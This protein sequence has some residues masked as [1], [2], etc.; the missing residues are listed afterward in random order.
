MD[1]KD[2]RD[3]LPEDEYLKQMS[4]LPKVKAPDDFL[5]KVR[6]RIERR[7]FRERMVDALFV[8][9]RIKIPL[10]VAAVTATLLLVISSL[11]V[12]RPSKHLASVPRSDVETAVIGKTEDSKARVFISRNEEKAKENVEAE[13]GMIIMDN[14]EYG[15]KAADHALED[16]KPVLQE[17]S[18]TVASLKI[19]SEPA[20]APASAPVEAGVSFECLK[21]KKMEYKETELSEAVAPSRG[22]RQADTF[23]AVTGL[24]AS[25]QGT[26]TGIGTDKDMGPAQ[27]IDAEIP[28]ANYELFKKKLED[29]AISGKV[30]MQPILKEAPQDRNIIQVRIIITGTF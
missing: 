13:K 12:I 9:F 25:V 16:S 19:A 14:I 22:L 21:A 10:E 6:E 2:K 17:K 11:D 23:S 4:S 7:T 8:P 15:G 26:V 3:M 27:Y 18:D 28:V 20:A 1:N 24:I 5:R 30:K 29:P